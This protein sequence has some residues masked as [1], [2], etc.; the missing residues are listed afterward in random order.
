MKRRNETKKVNICIFL[1]FFLIFFL[2][3]NMYLIGCCTLVGLCD[4]VVPKPDECRD[5]LLK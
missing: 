2:E 1:L 4:V 3:A 5:N